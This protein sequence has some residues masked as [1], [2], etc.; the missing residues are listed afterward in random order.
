M[1][2][3]PNLSLR[4]RVAERLRR[5]W[6]WKDFVAQAELDDGSRLRQG[7]HVIFAMGYSGG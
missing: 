4:R 7:R 2:L 6:T 1:K 3:C 5:I